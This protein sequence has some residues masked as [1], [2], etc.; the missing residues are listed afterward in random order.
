VFGLVAPDLPGEHPPLRSVDALPNNL[1]TT[2]STFIGREREVAELTELV[3]GHRIVSLVGAGGIGK[4]RTALQVAANLL[5]GSGD[6]VWFVELAPLAD[7]D[8]L[9]AA[10]AQ[11]FGVTLAVDSEP[12]AQIVRAFAAKTL[13]LVLDNC[14]HLIA[15]TALRGCPKVSILT[16]SRQPLNVAGERTYR[17]PSLPVPELAASKALSLHDA[18]QSA[19]VQLFV[20]RARAVDQKFELT[21]ANAETI[22]EI[23]RRLDGLALAIELAA[24][25]VTILSPR[26]LHARLDERFRV[27]TGGKRDVLPRQ[28]TLRA[29]I[30]WSYDLLDARTRALFARLGV[31]VGGFT[32]EAA[33]AVAG[34]DDLDEFGLIDVLTSLADMSLVLAEPAGDSMRYRMLE[35]T[36]AYAL[37]RAKADAD[38]S[39]A[40][41]HAAYYARY[42]A[43]AKD[44]PSPADR[45]HAIEIELE[46]LRAALAW[47]LGEQ[48][49]VDLGAHIA[50][51][52]GYYWHTRVPHEGLT[53]FERARAALTTGS[54]PVLASQLAS[55]HASMMPHGSRQRVEAARVAL[56]I[57]R[58]VGD[59]QLPGRLIAYAE[60]L[61][62]IDRL[63][64]AQAA[65][66]EGLAQGQTVGNDMQTARALSGLAMIALQRGDLHTARSLGEETLAIFERIGATDGVAYASMDLAAV[67]FRADNFERAAALLIRGRDISNELRNGRTSANASDCLA[68]LALAC[69]DLA[70]ARR[71][72]R[73]AL[74]VL[75]ADRHPQ[76]FTLAIA[77]LAFVATRHS[78]PRRGA[79][80][81]GYA[82][83]VLAN[84]AAPDVIL[85][86]CIAANHRELE[87]ALGTDDLAALLACGA[88]LSED[89][90]LAEA[91]AV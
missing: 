46:N 72:A 76:Y 6:G 17:L 9:P 67:E 34:T 54:D 87:A 1:P 21:D 41:R 40:A 15:A 64:E 81:H 62:V 39:L 45:L 16:T 79:V 25:R 49:D 10:V 77:A 55:G 24:A 56:E 42:A 29:L 36:R 38:T 5:D 91:L 75:R 35:S 57:S 70:Q 22:V 13:L 58:D 80:L 66:E 20:E 82:N 14:E 88:R 90:A 2:F 43:Q 84:L 27:L 73:D 31:F 4:T 8:Y 69:N 78:E 37:E 86:W 23:C 83:A 50:N 61:T 53:W 89:D 47:A 48:N 74:D 60:Q 68:A 65:F 32:L 33:V 19:A 28:Q 12:I 44:Q 18:S 52:M 3:R 71:H 11:Q 30:D 59:P 85:A 63:D 51:S 26:Q 7:D